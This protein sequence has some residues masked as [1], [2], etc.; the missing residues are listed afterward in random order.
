MVLSVDGVML[1]AQSKNL[2]CH[3]A[4]PLSK[5]TQWREDRVKQTPLPPVAA[6]RRG[7]GEWGAGHRWAQATHVLACQSKSYDA[8]P[9]VPTALPQGHV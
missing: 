2:W 9:G 4:S 8:A 3:L 7:G 5:W 6:A 1:L